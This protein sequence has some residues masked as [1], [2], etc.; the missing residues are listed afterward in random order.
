MVKMI[1]LAGT[2]L[3][4]SKEQPTATVSITLLRLG[5]AFFRTAFFCGG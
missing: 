4:E 2:L 1:S 5:A 3:L